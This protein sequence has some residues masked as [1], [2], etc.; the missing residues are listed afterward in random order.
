M[1]DHNPILQLLPIAFRRPSCSP[2]QKSFGPYSSF[3]PFWRSASEVVS[4][5]DLHF[6]QHLPSK[7][8]S[9]S[10]QSSGKQ[11]TSRHRIGS[12]LLFGPIPPVRPFAHERSSG[13]LI[14][15]DMHIGQHVPSSL[16]N[17]YSKGG[18]HS[19]I[20]HWMP[21]QGSGVS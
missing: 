17:A 21:S 2:G 20:A 6:V 16:G 12:A 3:M 8:W 9:Y 7:P 18:K 13:T 11:T 15:L 10:G 4:R 14:F 1:R 19:I 5:L